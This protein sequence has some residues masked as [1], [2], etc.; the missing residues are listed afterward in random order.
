[1]TYE[2]QELQNL[3]STPMSNKTIL[4]LKKYLVCLK[5]LIGSKYIPNRSEM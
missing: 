4:E 1:M 5:H 3:I 2:D